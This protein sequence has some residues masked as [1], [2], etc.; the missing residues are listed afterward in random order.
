MNQVDSNF[1]KTLKNPPKQDGQQLYIDA[2]VGHLRLRTVTADGITITDEVLPS[3][4]DLKTL[5]AEHQIH[6]RFG[7]HAQAPIFITGKLGP[8]VCQ[9]LGNGYTL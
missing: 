2:G 7:D 8:M 3:N 1:L 9:A 4:R 5:F 6:A